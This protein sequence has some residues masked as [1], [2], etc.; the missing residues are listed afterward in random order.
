KSGRTGIGTGRN[1]TL[2]PTSD[3]SFAES[4]E[5][6][7]VSSRRADGSLVRSEGEHWEFTTEDAWRKRPLG[8]VNDVQAKRARGSD[9]RWLRR[10]LPCF[11]NPRLRNQLPRA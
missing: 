9:S 1:W 2:K 10:S 6:R 5:S 11:Y 8:R 4:R 7:S 3:R